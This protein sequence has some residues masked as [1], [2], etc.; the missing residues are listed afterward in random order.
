MPY[1]RTTYISLVKLNLNIHIRSPASR[2]EFHFVTHVINKTKYLASLF[3]RLL[4]SISSAFTGYVG[5]YITCNERFSFLSPDVSSRSTKTS[6]E[7]IQVTIG[8]SALIFKLRME[9]GT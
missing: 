3:S 2:D 5:Q 1:L 4:F 7:N 6:L 8:T 9:C